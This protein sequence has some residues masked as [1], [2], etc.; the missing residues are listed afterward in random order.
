MAESSN[1]NGTGC[2]VLIGAE[3][4]F[5][6]ARSLAEA[7]EE[8]ICNQKTKTGT[9][10]IFIKSGGVSGAEVKSVFVE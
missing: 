4:K 1:G 6:I 9:L 2:Y 10:T 8:L 7:L 5:S 3:K